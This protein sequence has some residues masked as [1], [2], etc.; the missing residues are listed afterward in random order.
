[1]SEDL[2]VAV[3]GFG[4]AGEGLHAAQVAATPGLRV[5]AVVTANPQRAA[6]A[7]ELHPDAEVL[8]SADEVWARAGALDLVVVATPNRSHVPLGLEAVRRGLP[9]VVD[10]PLAASAAEAAELVEAAEAAGVPLSVYQNRRWDGDF[11]LVRRTLGSGVLGAVQRLEARFDVP[12]RPARGWRA[13]GD[14]AEGPGVL[15][16]LGAHLV[17]QALTLVGPPDR[18]YAELA[19]RGTGAVADDDAFLAPSR[20]RD[21]VVVHVWLSRSTSAP[22]PRFRLV[23]LDA[24]LTVDAPEDKDD[25]L[26]L[27]PARLQGRVSGLDVDGAVGLPPA[28][29]GAFYAGVRDAV[30]DGAPMPVDPRDALRTARVLDAARLSAET[31]QVVAVDADLRDHGPAR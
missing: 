31:R 13:S 16:D 11:L 22:G 8:A 17:D 29:T 30:R 10:K 15:L 20:D 6:R 9:V 2:A 24:T 14:P 3:L 4:M 19:A 27:A 26:R 1:M 28:E 5:A 25:P 21:D 7:R 18:V 12:L 23:G